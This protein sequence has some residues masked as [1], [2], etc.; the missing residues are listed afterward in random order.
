MNL[1]HVVDLFNLSINKV[2]IV[3]S[4]NFILR[5]EIKKMNSY[6][7]R[8]SEIVA[9]K[10][11]NTE[12]KSENTILKGKIEKLE[13]EV[14][15]TKKEVCRLNHNV[16]RMCDLL[17]EKMDTPNQKFIYHKGDGNSMGK[18]TSIGSKREGSSMLYP[19]VVE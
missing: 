6:Q 3:C 15:E 10:S 5:K 4:I 13:A 8:K 16:E 1:F 11:E 9:L 17:L 2:W 7:K 12:L 14:K 19:Y 18:L